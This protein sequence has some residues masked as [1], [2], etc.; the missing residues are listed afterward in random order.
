MAGKLRETLGI[1]EITS[2]KTSIW[3]TL[4][5]EFVGNLLLNF[6]GCASCVSVIGVPIPDLVLIALTFGFTIFIVVQVGISLTLMSI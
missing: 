3:K 1:N 4:V 5:A 6:F 2:K